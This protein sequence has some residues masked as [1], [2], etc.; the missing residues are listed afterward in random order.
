MDKKQ[1]F[2]YVLKCCNAANANRTLQ[3]FKVY[4]MR[5]RRFSRTDLT[6]GE[7]V[8]AFCVSNN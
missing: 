6:K 3:G 5:E 7:Q 2:F 8:T 4:S 1:Q